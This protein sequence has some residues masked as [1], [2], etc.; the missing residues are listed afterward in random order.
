MS[1]IY[2]NS[3]VQNQ[4]ELVK[5]A[6]ASTLQKALSFHS[7]IK[8]YNNHCTLEKSHVSGPGFTKGK[9]Y[10]SCL[11]LAQFKFRGLCFQMFSALTC[12]HIK[13]IMIFC[14]L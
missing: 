12:I 13:I 5:E 2:Y 3:K 1:L 9:I 4:E 6:V 10:L 7:M 8:A 11:R 14:L